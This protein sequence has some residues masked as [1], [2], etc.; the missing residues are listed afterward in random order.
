MTTARLPVAAASRTGP[1]RHFVPRHSVLVRITH[2][3]NVLCLTLLLMSGAQIFNAHPRLYWGEYGAD[4]D[5]AFLE[6][7]AVQDAT[8]WH[9]IFRVGPLQLRTTGVLGMSKED[10][11]MTRRA[12]PS[13]LT[14]PSWQDLATG[15]RW[16]FF[17]AWV[18][19][20]NGLVYLAGGF[21]RR[22]FSRDLLPAGGEM[23]GR[24]LWQEIVD[25]AR[26]QFARGEAARHYNVLQK[27]SY[28]A[29]VFV[30]LPMMVLTGLSMSPGMDAVFPFLPEMFGGRPSARALHFIT[31]SLLVAFVL[32]HVVMVLVSGLWNNLRS[33]ITGRY[34]IEVPRAAPPHTDWADDDA[35]AA[36]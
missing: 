7:G 22:H 8:G 1:V 13:W 5:A 28:L 20:A 24:H 30:L 2:W 27:L 29:V 3:I 19:V 21:L 14:I 33:M 26:L 23:R 25:H 18:F 32:V 9:G 35:G 34:A 17:W 16:H 11:A 4:F 31:A 12:F 10:G 6:I 15:R 36:S